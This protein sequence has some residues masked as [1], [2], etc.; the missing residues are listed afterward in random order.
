[1]SSNDRVFDFVAAAA[2]ATTAAAVGPAEAQLQHGSAAGSDPAVAHP[3]GL[4]PGGRLDRPRRA[5]T[6]SPNRRA[7]GGTPWGRTLG[8]ARRLLTL[9]SPSRGR[10]VHASP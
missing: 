4:A 5:R 1:M 2:T 7:R 10:S 8:R 9:S 6:T 3:P